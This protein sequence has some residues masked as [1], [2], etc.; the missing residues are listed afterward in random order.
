MR[1]YPGAEFV[2]AQEEPKNMGAWYYV[3]VGREAG[4]SWHGKSSVCDRKGIAYAICWFTFDLVSAVFTRTSVFSLAILSLPFSFK[5]REEEGRSDD[6]CALVGSLN[7]S[8][9]R[10]HNTTTLISSYHFPFPSPSP[11][12]SCYPEIHRDPVLPATHQLSLSFN[13]PTNFPT[14]F[15]SFL[16]NAGSFHD[17]QP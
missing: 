7:V 5:T 11:S 10:N 15:F 8:G 9:R 6:I 12:Q 2:W 17:R 4:D 3:Q 1:R 13:S 16:C 14:F